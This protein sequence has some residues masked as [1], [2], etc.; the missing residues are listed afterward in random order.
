MAA[1]DKYL[2]TKADILTYRPTAVLDDARI[3]PF[4]LEAQREDLCPVLNDAFYYAFV[5]DFDTGTGLNVT[6]AYEKLRTGG[7]YT[8]NSLTIQFDGVKPMLAYY[9]LARFIENNSLNIVRMG[10]VIKS[11]DQSEPADAKAIQAAINALRSSALHYQNQVIKF[12]DNNI[13]D[14][15]IY[16]T[17]GGSENT[18]TKTSFNFFR[19]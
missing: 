7:T 18:G 15:P 13:S 9:A 11:T 4:I 14:Y 2:I 10:V 12:L 6:A 3:K 16:N 5:N 1:L 17:G 19:L 8:Y